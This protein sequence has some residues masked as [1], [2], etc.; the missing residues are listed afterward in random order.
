MCS[1]TCTS[2]RIFTRRSAAKETPRWVVKERQFDLHHR[3]ADDWTVVIWV[4]PGTDTSLLSSPL[5]NFRLFPIFIFIPFAGPV[6][7]I[8][9]IHRVEVANCL[10][11][12]GVC[13]QDCHPLHWVDTVSIPGPVA[14]LMLLFH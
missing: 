9:N 2:R 4:S 7:H 5:S 12:K 8:Y 14:R 1:T 10:M 3:L 13:R 11:R 6:L